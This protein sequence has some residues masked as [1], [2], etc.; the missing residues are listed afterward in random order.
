MRRRDRYRNAARN[1]LRS[2]L[3]A[4]NLFLI[5]W[6]LLH[7]RQDGHLWWM[8]IVNAAVPWFFLPLPLFM[9]ASLFR[10]RWAVG[11][12]LPVGLF[13][14]LYGSLFL[15]RWPSA[16]AGRDEHLFRVMT[17]N[18]LFENQD[19]AGVAELVSRQSPDLVAFEELEPVAAQTFRQV[20]G[21]DYPYQA[22][23]PR[24]G[25]YGIGIFS[26]WPL[27][28]AQ[29]VVKRPWGVGGF[30]VD[31]ATP[32]ESPLHLVAVHPPPTL[33]RRS[34]TAYRAE[35]ERTVAERRREIRQAL[36]YL[37]ARPGPA[38]LLGDFNLTDQHETYQIITGDYGYKDSFREGGWGFGLTFPVTRGR[39]PLARIDYVF[40]SSGLR[41]NAARVVPEHSG[42]D[43]RPLV[44]DLNL[45]CSARA[46]SQQ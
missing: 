15:P 13:L 28:D 26:R 9:L 23:E 46:M 33:P 45:G 32:C 11:L 31:V 37:A 14:V 38:V 30:F 27:A 42:S 22:L 36:D 3:L 18:V 19:Y 1:V 25:P 17:F 39:F 40:H 29:V 35:I 4:Y 34:R 8:W 44:V 16:S 43:H 7:G 12:I 21:Q 2:L 6:L 5:A 41:T 20:L 24:N 10:R